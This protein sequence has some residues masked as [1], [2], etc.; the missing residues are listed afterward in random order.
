LEHGNWFTPAGRIRVARADVRGNGRASEEP[1]GDC[2]GS[3]F[4]CVDS[5]VCVVEASAVGQSVLGANATACVVGLTSSVDV[6]VGS[7]DG[8][9][10][11]VVVGDAAAAGSVESHGVGG[12][13]IDT[14]CEGLAEVAKLF[15]K[16]THQ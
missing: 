13:C 5:S 14:L 10:E 6:A 7:V 12:G 3:P 15:W 9:A 11:L 2:F 16:T 4:G 1:D 8:A